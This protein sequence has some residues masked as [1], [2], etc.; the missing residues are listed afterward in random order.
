MDASDVQIYLEDAQDSMT[1]A[2]AHLDDALLKIRAGK[3]SPSMLLGVVVDYYGAKT[4][5]TQVANVST[6]DARTIVI[7]PWEKKTIDLIEKG[8][9][10]ANIG[11]NPMNNGEVI[12]LSIPALTEERRKDL[13][14]QARTEGEHTKVSIRN[15]RRDVLEDIKKLKK[16]GLAEDAEKDAAEV[17]QKMTDA[18]IKKVDEATAKKEADIMVV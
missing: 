12:R 17:V 3:A 10:A 9:M 2:L 1:K 13:V 6:T 4:P 15:I 5:L 18:C 16:D 11:L 14:K 8:I 7:Q